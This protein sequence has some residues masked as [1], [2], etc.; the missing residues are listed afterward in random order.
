M[1]TDNQV[2]INITEEFPHLSRAP[3][4]EA[5]LDIRAFSEASWDEEGIRRSLIEKL[6]DYP[7]LQSHREYRQEVQLGAA[8][9]APAKQTFEDLGWRGF[10]LQSKED[11]HVAQF[12]HDGFVFSRL[13]PYPRWQDFITEGLRLWALHLE[14]ARPS[15]IQRIGLRFINRLPCP[16]DNFDLEE[17]LRTSPRPPAD[18]D[19]PYAGFFYQDTLAVPGHPFAMN[20]IKTIQPLQAGNG[21]GTSLI[22]DIDVYTTERSPVDITAI[23]DRVNR[24]RWLKNKA[25]FGTITAKEVE[26]LL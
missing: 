15:E 6:P 19:L 7:V 4:I 2:T 14:L 26:E 21:E 18:L 8:P 5:V 13:Q 1:T 16:F 11:P 20:I 12:N 3:I 22:V 23:E 10:R 9:E 17:Y 25:F 24:M